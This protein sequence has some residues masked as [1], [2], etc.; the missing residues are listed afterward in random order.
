V[1]P[2]L[3][4]VARNTEQASEANS[5]RGK[6][7]IAC[8]KQAYQLYKEIHASESFQR[9]AAA[10]ARP[11][12]LL[13]ASTATKNPKE[14]DVR[15]VEALIGPDTINTLT[16]Q[17]LVAFGDHGDPTPRLEE[18]L[19]E[20][21]QTLHLLKEV[22]VDLKGVGQ[23]LENEGIKKFKQPFDHLLG[24]LKRKLATASALFGSF[25]S[26]D[27]FKNT[28]DSTDKDSPPRETDKN[29]TVHSIQRH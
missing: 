28:L 15:Y 11:Q 7:A 22:G 24:E 6:T 21:R 10:G 19:D 12:R 17:T 27:G 5:L 16:R 8:A 4:E 2:L 1:D 13:W 14:R 29:P 23:Q 25:L 18:G 26:P 20:A 9:M 3:E